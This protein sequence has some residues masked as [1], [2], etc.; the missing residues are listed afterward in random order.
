[1]ISLYKCDYCNFIGSEEEVYKHENI[2]EHNPSRLNCSS[3]Q[4][5]SFKTMK[6]YKCTLRPEREI[7][8]NQEF[9]NCPDHS[10]REYPHTMKDIMGNIFGGLV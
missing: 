1:M 6:Q 8:E 7:P 4:Y 5:S 10:I 2:C 3:C 9:I